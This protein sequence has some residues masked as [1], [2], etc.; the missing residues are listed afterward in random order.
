MNEVTVVPSNRKASNAKRLGVVCFVAL[1]A[2]PVFAQAPTITV[3]YDAFGT[4]VLTQVQTMLA[5]IIPVAAVLFG[6][7]KGLSWLRSVI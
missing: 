3:D 2:V 7:M 6:T 4:G 1:A 5:A